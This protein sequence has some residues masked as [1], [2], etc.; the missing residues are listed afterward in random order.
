MD[1]VAAAEAEAEEA[2]MIDYL[3]AIDIYYMSLFLTSFE[4][5]WKSKNKNKI[6]C[7][8]G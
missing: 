5:V 8:I 1:N 7:I 3:S 6:K 2:D 4:G